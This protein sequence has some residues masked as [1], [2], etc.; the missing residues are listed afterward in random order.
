MKNVKRLKKDESAETKPTRTL[1]V[2]R[3]K[4]GEENTQIRECVAKAGAVKEMYTIRDSTA[5]LFVIMY[6][7]RERVLGSCGSC[8]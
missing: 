8:L 4:N 6:D 2:S 5:I 7:I 1:L 3:I